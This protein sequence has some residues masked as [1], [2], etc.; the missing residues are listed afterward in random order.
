MTKECFYFDSEPGEV[1]FLSGVVDVLSD[2]MSLYCEYPST[3]DADIFYAPDQDLSK[4]TEAVKKR[5]HIYYDNL[6]EP[7]MEAKIDEMDF[8]DLVRKEC[9]PDAPSI[10]DFIKT[11]KLSATDE[12]YYKAEDEFMRELKWHLGKPVCTFH[13]SDLQD[14]N[15][16]VLG[17]AY[18]SFAFT[19]EFIA[20]QN[21]MVLM[22]HGTSE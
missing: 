4:L 5:M 19:Y 2:N 22:I 7:D 3:M 8:T 11:H 17:H 9:N 6:N 13:P 1:A 21:Y 20:Y 16:G 14:K 12:A 15:I 10:Q 18:M